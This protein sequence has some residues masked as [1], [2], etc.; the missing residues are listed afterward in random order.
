M[1]TLKITSHYHLKRQIVIPS[2]IRTESEREDRK[3]SGMRFPTFGNNKRATFLRFGVFL[4]E[5]LD[6]EITAGTE[7]TE[8]GRTTSSSMC[9]F[10]PRNNGKKQRMAGDLF[11][12]AQLNT[13]KELKHK[14]IK[15]ER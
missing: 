3:L 2:K 8:K 10:L 15:E 11:F 13:Q 5:I 6:N 12:D 4:F 7:P 14:E 1:K 9:A